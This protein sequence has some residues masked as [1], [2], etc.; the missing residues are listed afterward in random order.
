MHKITTI[1]VQLLLASALAASGWDWLQLDLPSGTRERVWRDALA[2]RLRGQE[3]ALEAVRT[4]VRVK[5]G[6]ID[7]A[8]SNEVIEVEFPHKWKEGMGQ[9]L[10]YAGATGKQPVLALISYSQGPENLQAKSRDTFDQAEKECARHGVRLL[11]L[12]PAQPEAFAHLKTNRA[13]AATAPAVPV[14]PA[15]PSP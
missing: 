4:E 3:T 8:T 15:P 9:A 12:F 5:T 1:A 10:A 13:A 6:H 14:T 2:A 11:V 7:V